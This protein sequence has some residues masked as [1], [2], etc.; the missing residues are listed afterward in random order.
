MGFAVIGD[1]S[2]NAMKPIAA[3]AANGLENCSRRPRQSKM[4]FPASRC[5]G[6]K[7]IE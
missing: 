5:V 6:D 3:V 1:H 2:V 7:V 4:E